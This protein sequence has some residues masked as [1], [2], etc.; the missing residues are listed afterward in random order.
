M[1]GRLAGE[2]EELLDVPA[3]RVIEE[4]L[5]LVGLVQVRKPRGERAVP[6]HAPAGPRQ[7]QGDVARE[8]DP[9]THP[10]SVS[11]GLTIPACAPGGSSRSCS[12]S[13]ASPVAVRPAGRRTRAQPSFWTSP[14]TPCT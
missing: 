12:P 11:A 4:P 14:R 13:W 2:N 7:R 6:A 10:P 9:A 3:R 5:D 8:R 1:V